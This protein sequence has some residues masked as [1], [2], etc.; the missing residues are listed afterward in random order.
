MIRRIFGLFILFFFA[1][2]GIVRAQISEGGKPMKP[3]EL[4]SSAGYKVEMPSYL[5]FFKSSQEEIS[6]ENKLKSL[7]FAYPYEVNLTPENSGEWFSG[8]NGYAIWKLTIRSE[9]AYSIYLIFNDF[10]LPA[11]S[12]LFVYSETEDQL[13]GAFTA[14]NNSPSHKFAVAPVAGDEITVQLEMPESMQKSNPFRIVKVMHDYTGILKSDDR[15]PLGLSGSCNVNVNCESWEEWGDNKNSVVRIITES[16]EVC[17]G[18]LVNNTAENQKPFILSAS[19]CYDRWNY[20]ETAVYVFNYE[21]PFCKSLDGD[22]VNSISGAVMKA[23][24]DSLDFALALLNTVPSPAYQ[25]YYTGWNRSTSLPQSMVTI[26][27]PQG[28][29]KKIASDNGPITVA[30]FDNVYVKNAFL[31]V[32]RWDVGVTEAGSSGGPF[33]D[34]NKLLVGTLTGGQAVCGNPVNDYCNRFSMA[35]DFKSDTT[36]QLKHWLDPVKSGVEKINGK[37]FN[38]GENLCGTIS[39]LTDNDSYSLISALDGTAFAGYWGGSNSLGIT[40]VMEKFTTEAYLHIHGVSL[41]VAKFKSKIT[42]A[43]STITVKVYTGFSQPDELI[44]SQDVS[45]SSLV[46]DALNYIKF[47]ETVVAGRNFFVGF[48]LT[49]I[50]PLDSFAVYQ[51]LR[52]AT[53]PNQLY[54]KINNQW[55][56][57]TNNN[58]AKKSM[59]S[60]IELVACNIDDFSTDT[61]LV[62]NPADILVFPNPVSMRFTVEAGQEIPDE[63]NISVMN[64]LGQECATAKKRL[65]ERKVEIDMGGNVPGIYFVRFNTG[66]KYITRKISYVPW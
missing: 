13:L 23:Q 48:E 64:L 57:Y 50:Q 32:A 27:H 61:P 42:N 22:P 35:W 54:L 9:D 51:S 11:H 49:N 1:F 41:G 15:R 60:I 21:S 40:E 53:L 52:A 33:F 17:S 56:S 10:E 24:Y 30:S 36:K 43:S 4:K 26:H 65:S 34:Q 63:G 45:T 37:Q 16:G 38:T 31:K 8:D 6:G 66:A 58:D 47:T 2:G 44:Y 18:V 14:K 12:K 55:S 62:E 59:V 29:I 3:R 39:N 25:P 46:A 5:R 20:A 28:D 19:H 7:Q